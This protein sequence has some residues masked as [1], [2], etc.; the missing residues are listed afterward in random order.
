MCGRYNLGM[1]VEIKDLE[2]ILDEVRRH[3][4]DDTRERLKTHGEIRPTNVVPVI[5]KD[6]PKAMRWGM[7]LFDGKYPNVFNSR[8]DKL[9]TNEEYTQMLKAGLCCLI[10]IVFYYEWKKI[11]GTEKIRYAFRLPE[12][13]LMYAAGIYKTEGVRLPSFSIIT[14]TPNKDVAKIH[15]RMPLLLSKSAQEGWLSPIGRFQDVLC[16]GIKNVA[17]QEDDDTPRQIRMF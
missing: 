9:M 16:N 15:D 5:T 12:K 8:D 17:Y 4:D 3:L 13:P 7:P 10:P 11:S 2:D 1:E 6:G 14:T